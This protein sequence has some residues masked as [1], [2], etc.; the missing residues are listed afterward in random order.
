MN[1]LD[2]ASAKLGAQPEFAAGS[3]PVADSA[4][5]QPKL[6]RTLA[7]A[8]LPLLVL[9]V[10]LLVLDAYKAMPQIFS[11]SV[12]GH[13]VTLHDFSL[14]LVRKFAI[15]ALVLPIVFAVEVASGGWQDSSLRAIF[16]SPSASIRSDITMFLLTHSPFYRMLRIVFTLG[17]VYIAGDV[18]RVWLQHVA[19]VNLSLAGLTVP[20]MFIAYAAI[21]TFF[22]YWAHR[23]Q[24]TCVFWPIHRFHH[25]AEEFSVFTVD[26]VHPGDFPELMLSVFVVGLFQVTATVYLLYSVMMVSLR[27]LIHSRIDSD[28]GWVGRWLVLSPAHHRAHH[29]ADVNLSGG[30]FA[31]IP[32]WDRLF[33]TLRPTAS[34]Q[35]PIGI[36]EPYRHGYWTISDMARD[37]GDL[38]RGMLPKKV[39]K[40]VAPR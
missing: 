9:G 7:F 40:P 23:L 3:D 38:V 12:L 25:A 36:D 20:A 5:R 28:F 16:N 27:Y 10:A 37:A 17:L 11:R 19:G 1:T 35:T 26:R 15:P 21:D 30:N 14:M 29:L 33:G 32:L 8:L 13:V 18:A 2:H 22:D 24:H 34:R 39:P 4:A 6:R 31:L